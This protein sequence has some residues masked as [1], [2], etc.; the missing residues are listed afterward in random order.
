MKLSAFTD[1]CLKSLIY[2]KQ[3]NRLVTI[4][5]I[6]NHFSIPRNHLVK[7]LNV[8]VKFKWINSIR[9]R[10]GGLV[11]NE[12]SDS[13][14]IGDIILILE[15]K[16]ELLNCEECRLHANCFLRF[17]LKDSLNAFYT[18]LNKYTLVDLTRDAPN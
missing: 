13:L 4:N 9:G 10:N 7:A 8:L 2:L 15:S 5:E 14:K 17:I 12:A 11:Y 6:S 16:P 18:N 3:N 1:I